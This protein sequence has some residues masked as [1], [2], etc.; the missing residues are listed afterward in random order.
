VA[1]VIIQIMPSAIFN[2]AHCV[3]LV[4]D[5]REIN[6]VVMSKLTKLED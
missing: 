4:L 6:D 1:H 5:V 2:F 3:F